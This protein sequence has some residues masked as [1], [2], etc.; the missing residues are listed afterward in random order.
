MSKEQREA[1]YRRRREGGGISDSAGGM[2]MAA[3]RRVFA[4]AQSAWPRP[5]GTTTREGT[6]G[7]VPVVHVGVADV[8]ASSEDVILYFHGGAYAV[9]SA[10]TGVGL[11]AF[12]AQRTGAR[13]VSV[14]Y[15]LAPEHPYPAAVDDAVAAY[16]ALLEAG[17]RPGRIAFAGTSAGGGLAIAALLAI[18]AAGLPQPA[19]AAV[20]SPWVDLTL[21]G[22]SVTSKAGFDVSLSPAGLRALASA[23]AG[24]HDPADGRL[25]PIF[26]DL[27]GLPPLLI[28]AG[29]YEILL[30][31][32]TRLATRAAADEVDVTLEI[33]AGATHV[34]QTY[35]TEIDEG[36]DALI[37]AGAFIRGQLDACV[38]AS[39]TAYGAD[40][41]YGGG[42]S[43]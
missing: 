42:L 8:V 2:D 12:L 26:A 21:S 16:R 7:G 32:A 23:Y 39:G 9:G 4:E 19:A 25:S 31:D 6:L 27:R 13:V 15:R 24:A 40:G 17:D 5:D 28:Q 38:S 37:N 20:F 22:A 34:F 11:P 18:K 33:T 29:T 14:E 35:W 41:A 36:R 10:A 43:A 1:F 3:R 30:D